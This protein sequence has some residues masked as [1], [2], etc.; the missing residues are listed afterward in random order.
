[1]YKLCARVLHAL[2]FV[3]F[4][5]HDLVHV[6]Q[7]QHPIQVLSIR[8]NVPISNRADPLNSFGRQLTSSQIRLVFE[9]KGDNMLGW[10]P[11]A[12]H[13]ES[14]VGYKPIRTL[15]KQTGKHYLPSGV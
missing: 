2:V 7:H 6:P 1:M 12:K 10:A 9:R 5:P 3:P 4:S 11:P 14:C 13:R 15:S 8:P